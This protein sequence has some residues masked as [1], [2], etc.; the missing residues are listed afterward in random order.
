MRG[1]PVSST[2]E[3]VTEPGRLLI[4]GS[5][6]CLPVAVGLGLRLGEA[7]GASSRSGSFP[8]SDGTTPDSCLPPSVDV[9]GPVV[10]ICDRCC[11]SHCRPRGWRIAVQRGV[12]AWF[13]HGTDLV[14]KSSTITL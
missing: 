12:V 9:S 8:G 1:A 5:K 6:P 4:I 14:S 7:L 10:E 11:K 13:D 3:R 2:G